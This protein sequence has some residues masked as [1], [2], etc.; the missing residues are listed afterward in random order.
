MRFKGE[1]CSIL[2]LTVR[3]C[4]EMII[5]FYCYNAIPLAANMFVTQCGKA[6]TRISA[7]SRI[8]LDLAEFQYGAEAGL[9]PARPCD[10]QILNL[11]QKLSFI[12]IYL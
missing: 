11:R 9:E 8:F 6:K 2:R 10:R 12:D 7:G 5:D 3:T 1:H 4:C